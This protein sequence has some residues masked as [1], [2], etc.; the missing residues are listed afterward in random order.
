MRV[1]YFNQPWWL[2]WLLNSAFIGSAFAVVWVVQVTHPWERV[3]PMVLTIALAGYGLTAGALSTWGQ[4]PARRAYAEAYRGLTPAQRADAARALRGGALPADHQ[5]LVGALRAG[6]IAEQYYQRAARGRTMQVV[7]TAGIAI[8]AVVDLF[9]R[10][11]RHGILLLVLAAFIG[12]S[13]VRRE[14]RRA[15]LTTRL[16]E[17]RSAAEVSGDIDAEDLTP[18]P[19]PRQR[20]VWL[21]ALMVVAVGVGGVGFAALSSQPRRDCR[22]AAAALQLVH[23]RSDLLDLKTIV[24]G[25]PDLAAYR[26]W[27]D[28]LSRLAGQVSAADIAPHLRAIADRARDGISLVA[29]ARSAPPPR[30]VMDLQLAYGQDML[31][32][33]DEENALTAACHTR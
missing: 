6:A 16:V 10:D 7:S 22:T 19:R 13:T 27:A 32:I 21:L 26:K 17:L 5:V 9:L 14:Y 11:W 2:R 23:A 20:N 3:D 25:G 28:Q 1:R 31:S 24:V 8:F 18:P 33:M 12:A 30:P 29:Q 4:Q 15:Q